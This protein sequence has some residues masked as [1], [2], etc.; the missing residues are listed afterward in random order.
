MRAKGATDEQLTK[1]TGEA[2]PP[3]PAPAAEGTAPSPTGGAAAP[4][5]EPPPRL[6]EGAV[7]PVKGDEKM[8]ATTKP[9]VAK[10]TAGGTTTTKSKG[11]QPPASGQ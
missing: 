5:A 4:A 11:L 6:P 10:P 1:I 2:P 9:S 7:V 3:P 8:K